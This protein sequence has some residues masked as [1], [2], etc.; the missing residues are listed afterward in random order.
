MSKRIL[1]LGFATIFILGILPFFHSF[2]YRAGIV[3]SGGAPPYTWSVTTSNGK[4]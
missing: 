3:A 4:S 1:S 2:G